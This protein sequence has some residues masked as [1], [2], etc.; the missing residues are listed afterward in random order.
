MVS[1]IGRFRVTIGKIPPGRIK[2]LW[3]SCWE[4]SNAELPSATCK[5]RTVLFCTIQICNTVQLIV[6]WTFQTIQLTL[7][8]SNA[9]LTV[10]S[11]LFSYKLSP[12]KSIVSNYS[13]VGVLEQSRFMLLLWSRSNY[14]HLYTNEC[15]NDH[16]R[17]LYL[18][19]DVDIHCWVE[20]LYS[21]Y[22]N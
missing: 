16:K 10:V 4:L 11:E 6:F 22:Y 1:G 15:E 7:F 20:C 5:S 12:Y 19:S 2:Q 8:R 13:R 9:L 14:L 21:R 18:K 17:S 3:L